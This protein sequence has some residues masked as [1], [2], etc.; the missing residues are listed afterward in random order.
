MPEEGKGRD[1]FFAAL[2]D[3]LPDGKDKEVVVGG[4]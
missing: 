4:T 1:L 3:L 2:G